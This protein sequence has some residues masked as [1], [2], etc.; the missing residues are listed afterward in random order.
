MTTKATT[1][2]A[3]GLHPQ[4]LQQLEKQQITQ[5]TPV[6]EAAIPLLLQ[7]DDVIARAQTGTGKTLAFLLPIMEK[8]Q[9]EQRV[10]QAL[11]V[12]PTRELAI[13]ITQEAK[14]LTETTSINLL[15]AY[16]GQDVEKQLHRL[17]GN[18]HLVVG[19]PGRLLD[20]L[21]RGTLDLSD[22]RML[23][24]DEAD[25]MLH[26]GFLPEVEAIINQTPPNRQTMLFSATIPDGVQ[27]LARRFTQSARQVSVKTE[28]VTLTEIQQL[29]IET[30]DRKKQDALCQILGESPPFM[31]I[32]FCR[33][34]RR[35]AAL[36]E[37]L[38]SWGYLS[39]EL[40][41]DLTQAKRE[42]VMKSFRKAEI[43]LLVATD[44]AAR[45][46]DIEGITH[47]YNYDMV[48]DVD[49]Y[50]HRI[51]RTGR[52]GQVGTA[53]T[54]VTPRDRQVLHEVE[55]GIRMTLPKRQIG[56]KFG[57][58][59]RDPRD[60]KEK[61]SHQPK[62][63]KTSKDG[64]AGKNRGN[65]GSKKTDR[66]NTFDKGK[67]K[68]KDRDKDR[69]RDR[70]RDKGRG[71]DKDK[72]KAFDKRDRT[73]D[74]EKSRPAERNKNKMTDQ[75]KTK[76]GKPGGEGGKWTPKAAGTGGQGQSKGKG[77]GPWT[78]R[79]KGNGNGSGGKQRRSARSR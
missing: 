53:V 59:E 7:G 49:N 60:T 10:V 35:A 70:D 23:V 76:D 39:D 63:G 62:T 13:Q 1:F 21:R 42:K 15:A 40:H 31:A 71:R 26:M 38:Q 77:K 18:I 75:N 74:G 69:D 47:I 5:P 55:K 30:T 36:N 61:Q 51:G 22:L 3:L 58:E 33:T 2:Q 9:P 44:V 57:H 37:E 41:G 20:H 12:T 16:G 29:V 19:T 17:K 68:G 11:V 32:I 45:G 25:Q 28:T 27:K 65:A 56:L 79:P 64:N 8:I 73:K 14:K 66:G 46:L 52:A 54:F 67:G 43:Q 4:W 6:Q 34:R 50:I 48:Q 78:S 24:L 72:N